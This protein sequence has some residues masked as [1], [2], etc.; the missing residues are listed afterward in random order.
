M[1]K[2]RTF[3]NPEEAREYLRGLGQQFGGGRSRWIGKI[4]ETWA[5]RIPTDDAGTTSQTEAPQRHSQKASKRS[6]TRGS[7]STPLSRSYQDPVI[8]PGDS[9]VPIL[10]LVLVL[11]LI[12][13]AVAVY[14][15]R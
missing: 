7:D 3:N 11:V 10:D 8:Q 9:A 15:F 12:A 5:D 1:K 2:P 4:L 6:W 13:I 14:V